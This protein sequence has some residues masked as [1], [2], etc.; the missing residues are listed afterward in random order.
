MADSSTQALIRGWYADHARDLPWRAAGVSGWEVL[1]S[2]VMLQQTPVERVL[3]VYRDWLQRWP[4]PSALAADTVGAAL[5]MWGRLGYPRRALRLHQA[6]TMIHSEYDGEVPSDTGALQRLPGVGEYTA[7]AVSAFAYRQRA[8]VLDT[9]VRR[10]LARLRTAQP[11]PPDGAVT[12]RERE[13]AA[14]LLPADGEAAARWSVAVMELGALVCTAQHPT[15]DR[16]PVAG[17]CEWRRRGYPAVDAPPRRT[18]SYAGTDRQ[19][20]GRI[21]ALLRGTP[22]RVPRHRVDACWSD[23]EQRERALASLIDDGLVIEADDGAFA[24]P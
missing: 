5:R 1:V 8:L 7:A 16:C 3:P 19:C 22:D 24:L 18:Q 12:R 20:R 17:R 15:C 6:A 10:V 2:E 14:A 13:S 4:T 23:P 21:M 11:Y 9:N